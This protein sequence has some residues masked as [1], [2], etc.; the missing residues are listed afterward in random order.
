MNILNA[1]ILNIRPASDGKSMLGIV[2][3][4]IANEPDSDIATAHYDCKCAIPAANS[5]EQRLEQIRT[6]LVNDALR[7][8]RRMPEIRS[9]YATLNLDPAMS[10]A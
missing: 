8:V 10:A 2:T 5:T 9:G 3:F 1:E 4:S 7:Q 6:G